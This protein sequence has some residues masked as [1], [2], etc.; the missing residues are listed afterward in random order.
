MAKKSRK[1]K[2]PVPKAKTKP[3][4][5]ARTA[6]KLVVA[7]QTAR[8]VVRASKATIDKAKQAPGS[9][10]KAIE[11]F[12]SEAKAAGHIAEVAAER[13]TK[14]IATTAGVVVGIVESVSHHEPPATD[15]AL[16]KPRQPKRK[17]IAT[18]KKSDEH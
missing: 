3:S 5:S 2:K 13:A 12:K 17:S 14:V 18:D 9:A 1:T 10:R 15:E 16:K 8:T 6:A 4:F 11:K 7:A